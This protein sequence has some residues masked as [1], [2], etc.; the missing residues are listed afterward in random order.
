[1][2]LGYV[3]DSKLGIGSHHLEY[4]FPSSH[5]TNSISVA[6]YILLLLL[7]SPAASEPH[8][9]I[10][11]CVLVATYAFSIVF[12]RLYC[13]MHSFIDC[14]AGMVLGSVITLFYWNYGPLLEL[15]ISELGWASPILVVA[16]WMLLL[17]QF[18]QPVDDCPCFE[19]AIAFVS[20]EAGLILGM[21]HAKHLGVD[22]VRSLESIIGKRLMTSQ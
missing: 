10:P 11:C 22:K 16:A 21:W 3:S 19:D 15:W 7:N 9:F 14:I 6:L 17:N 1:M 5:T 4:G 20:V 8:L 18:P 12:G 13:G 2:H